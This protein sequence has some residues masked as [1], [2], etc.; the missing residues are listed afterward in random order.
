MAIFNSYVSLPGGIQDF[1]GFDIAPFD[2]HRMV[3]VLVIQLVAMVA[4]ATF[5]R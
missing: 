4:M 5:K 3:P 2:C 1:D